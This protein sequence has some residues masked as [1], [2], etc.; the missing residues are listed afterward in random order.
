MSKQIP[1][2]ADD[3]LIRAQDTPNPLALKFIINFTLKTA[4]NATYTAKDQ[5]L[6]LPLAAALFDVPGIEQIYFFQNT[7]TVTHND[8]LPVDIMKEQ[9]KSII[10]TRL[11]VHDPDFDS[12]TEQQSKTRPDRSS[13]SPEL[14]AVEEILDRTIRP[15]LQ[16]D[17]GDVEI[18]EFKDNVLKIIYQGACGGCP[19]S[20]MGTLDAIQSILRNELKND[21]ITVQPI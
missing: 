7:V 10:K 6:H 9:V 1:I 11:S 5:C 19:S 17:G 8:E 21:S 16:S 13:L 12:P 2:S 20:M 18:V 3:I 15:G 4:G 14:R